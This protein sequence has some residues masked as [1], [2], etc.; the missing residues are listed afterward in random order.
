MVK[1][2]DLRER[3]EKGR[4][5]E[6]KMEEQQMEEQQMEELKVAQPQRIL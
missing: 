6:H 1:Q 2:Q 4:I 3:R 5:G